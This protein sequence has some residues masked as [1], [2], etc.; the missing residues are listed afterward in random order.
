MVERLGQQGLAVLRQGQIV[1]QLHQMQAPTRAA[2]VAVVVA[3]L[4]ITRLVVAATAAPVL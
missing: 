4:Q 3:L 1:I 2:A